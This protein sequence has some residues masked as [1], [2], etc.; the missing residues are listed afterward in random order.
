MTNNNQSQTCHVNTSHCFCLR[1]PEPWDPTVYS[2]KCENNK[3]TQIQKNK[4]KRALPGGGEVNWTEFKD[5]QDCSRSERQMK[6]NANVI[7]EAEEEE[8]KKD[9]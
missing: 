4:P 1:A 2:K 6:T 5:V 7:G 8:K 3:N 9:R